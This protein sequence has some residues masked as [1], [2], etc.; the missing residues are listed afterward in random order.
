MIG[1]SFAAAFLAA[2]DC[3]GR[4][5]KAVTCNISGGREPDPILE[6]VLHA[7]GDGL[8]QRPQPKRL[9][10]HESVQGD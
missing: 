8:P 4:E 10:D 5:G 6:R 1:F 9:P 3:A 2:G 7:M